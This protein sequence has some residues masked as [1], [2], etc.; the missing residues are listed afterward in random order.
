MI[1]LVK[2]AELRSDYPKVYAMDTSFTQR[3]KQGYE[4]VK[5]WTKKVDI[6]AYDIIVVPVNIVTHVENEETGETEATGH[7]CMAIIN[8][9]EKTIKYYD[10]CYDDDEENDGLSTLENLEHYLKEESKDKKKKELDFS[11]WSKEIVTN[12]P[13]QGNTYDCGVF[14]CMTAEF[15]CR[16]RPIIF[17][18][19]N[20]EYFRKKMILE[21]CTGSMLL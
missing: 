20:M 12:H 11:G 3:L 7:W 8:I 1:L 5:K 15:I 18:Q 14:S 4:T 16:N 9:K 10:S 13:Q 6:F 21:I 2:R 19:E 17:K